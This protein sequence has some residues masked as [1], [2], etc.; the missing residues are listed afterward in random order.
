MTN[1]CEG[2]VGIPVLMYN[3][4]QE[5][6]LSRAN[7]DGR[8]KNLPR[9]NVVCVTDNFCRHHHLSNAHFQVCFDVLCCIL[10][11]KCLLLASL[12]RGSTLY[13]TI[14]V[15]SQNL[16]GCKNRSMRNRLFSYCLG[17]HSCTMTS[18]KTQVDEIERCRLNFQNVSRL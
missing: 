11:L 15:T 10:N 14:A 8:T 4:L 6:K 17:I 7:C 2:Y 3:R 18:R 16:F 9:M 12:R 13:C 1:N 5:G